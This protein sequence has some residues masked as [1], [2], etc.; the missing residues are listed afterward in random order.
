MKEKLQNSRERTTEGTSDINLMTSAKK[1][2]NTF[3]AKLQ[4]DS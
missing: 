4:F 1:I 2:L 3:K